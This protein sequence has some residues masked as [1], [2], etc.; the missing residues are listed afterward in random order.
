[1]NDSDS[2]TESSSSWWEGLY[3]LGKGYLSAESQ[4]A[5][6]ESQE[7]LAQINSNTTTAIA[8]IQ[9]GAPLAP[10]QTGGSSLPPTNNTAAQV[11]G[12]SFSFGN[13][14]LKP[15]IGL[16]LAGILLKKFL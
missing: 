5:E 10:A 4:K 13:I 15:L 14:N 9:S 8:R 2:S 11:S 7:R 6:R 12:G 16:A 3:A 1:M